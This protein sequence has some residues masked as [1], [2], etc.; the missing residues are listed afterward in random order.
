MSAQKPEKQWKHCKNLLFSCSL[1]ICVHC[2]PES[3]KKNFGQLRLQCVTF[4]CAKKIVW[5][6]QPISLTAATPFE[7]CSFQGAHLWFLES[8]FSLKNTK[9]SGNRVLFT[10]HLLFVNLCS[11]KNLHGIA[12]VH[13]ACFPNPFRALSEIPTMIND[14]YKNFVL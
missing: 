10:F 11:W 3:A 2:S 14:T 13:H 1:W 8:V 5:F 12:L 7:K 9:C 4:W 6:F